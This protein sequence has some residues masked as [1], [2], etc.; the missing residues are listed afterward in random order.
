[1]F[2]HDCNKPLL[3]LNHSFTCCDKQRCKRCDD[4][5]FQAAHPFEFMESLYA[6][7]DD[8]DD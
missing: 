3:T 2:C 6:G 1:M 4:L 8:T 5:H 7:D